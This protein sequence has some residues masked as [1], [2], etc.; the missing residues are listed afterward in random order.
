MISETQIAE[1][2]NLGLGFYWSNISK[3]YFSDVYEYRMAI[4]Y[5]PLYV[6][7]SAP[8]TLRA[9]RWDDDTHQYEDKYERFETFE[10]LKAYLG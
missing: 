10:E 7:H 2:N 6:G 8:F 4:S 3:E 1:L 9:R 5:D